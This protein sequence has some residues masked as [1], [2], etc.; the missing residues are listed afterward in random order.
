MLCVKASTKDFLY[1]TY[2]SLK[3]CIYRRPTTF[4]YMNEDSKIIKSEL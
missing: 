3:K 2:V 1:S 4:Y